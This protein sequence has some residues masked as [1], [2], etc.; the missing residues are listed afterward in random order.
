MVPDYKEF[1]LG[2]GDPL[3]QARMKHDFVM[4]SPRSKKKMIQKLKDSGDIHLIQNLSPVSGMGF[5]DIV[6]I[7]KDTIIS[8]PTLPLGTDEV[9]P[10][11]DIGLDV[12][13]L[14]RLDREATP[15]QDIVNEQ[16]H[17]P[18]HGSPL[19]GLGMSDIV[20]VGKDVVSIPCLPPDDPKNGEL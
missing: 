6:H 18:D 7:D 1:R 4:A 16:D 10:K 15:P 19:A 9:Q 14:P 11:N 8:F 2:H 5:N 20:H 13:V 12:P 17:L 3:L